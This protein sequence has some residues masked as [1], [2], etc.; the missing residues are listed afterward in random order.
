MYSDLIARNGPARNR[1]W[2]ER[3]GENLFSEV[4]SRLRLALWQGRFWGNQSVSENLTIPENREN[5]SKRC[6]KP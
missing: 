6:W 2:Y 3:D 4:F 5:Y 1:P